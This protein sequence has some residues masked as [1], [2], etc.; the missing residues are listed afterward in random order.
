MKKLLLIGA[1]CAI[2]A[3]LAFAQ[4]APPPPPMEGGSPLVNDA[5]SQWGATMIAQQNY[6]RASNAVLQDYAKVTAD[7]RTAK[8][9]VA[10]LQAEL[11]KEQAELAKN[12]KAL[13]SALTELAKKSGAAPP[14]PAP[15]PP[16]PK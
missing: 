7:L 5:V 13:D 2:S 3:P 1:M 16:A 4:V 6:I 15:S 11:A 12:Q 14:T 8:E 9:T 10:T